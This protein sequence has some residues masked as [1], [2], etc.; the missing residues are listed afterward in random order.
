MSPVDSSV[1]ARLVRTSLGGGL[2]ITAIAELEGGGFA[3]VSRVDLSDGRTVVLKVAPPPGPLLSYEYGVTGA[4]ARYLALVERRLPGCPFPGLLAHGHD[5]R[6]LDSEW[7]F[8]SYLPGTVL[9]ALRD[10]R[11]PEQTD[12]VRA[13][14]GATIARLHAVTGGRFGYDDSRPHGDSWREAF[15]AMVESLLDDARV[16]DVDLGVTAEDIRGLLARQAVMLDVVERPSLLHF[17][18]WDGNLLCGPDRGGALRL[19]G[20]VDG[21][22]YLWGDPLMDFVSPAL[23][24]RI[25]DEPGH[26][27]V[28]GYAA[29][30]DRPVTFDASAARRLACYRL[31]MYLLM[32]VEMPSRG[33]TPGTH[34]GRHQRLRTLL[35]R[36]LA[37]LR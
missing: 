9:T 10:I 15:H 14:L 5:P 31:H 12:R 13:D 11:P 4:E 33:M 24:R 26:P 18:L 7:I 36:E 29:A 20:I 3:T 28:R 30:Q 37:A 21:E 16:W 6:I 19:T 34:P 27:F 35:Q 2:E 1:A 32:T 25:E 22:R 23:Y 8:I 17:D